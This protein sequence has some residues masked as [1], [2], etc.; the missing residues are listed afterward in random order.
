MSGRPEKALAFKCREKDFMCVSLS[1][2]KLC[3]VCGRKRER[4]RKKSREIK[5]ERKK[6]REREV[7]LE[8]ERKKKR[9]RE[10]HLAR[11]R[12]REVALVR[13]RQAADVTSK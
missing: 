2:F 4:E 11:V 6:T 10:V 1:C 3:V 8:R 12:E 13:R 5:K 9:E 7:H